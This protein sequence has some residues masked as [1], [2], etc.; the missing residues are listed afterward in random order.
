MEKRRARLNELKTLE[1]KLSE[2]RKDIMLKIREKDAEI[3]TLERRI[4]EIDGEQKASMQ[5]RIS[6]ELTIDKMSI[7]RR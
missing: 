4:E 2:E 7:T 1:S 3:K 5:E 6:L